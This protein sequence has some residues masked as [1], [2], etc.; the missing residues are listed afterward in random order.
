MHLWLQKHREAVLV[1]LV[2]NLAFGILL[3]LVI[4]F[5]R[6][7]IP[8]AIVISPLETPAPGDTGLFCEV[9]VIIRK[10]LPVTAKPPITGWN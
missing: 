1:G 10:S 6:R 4:I 7:P 5:L 9:A 3:G 2:Q 8:A